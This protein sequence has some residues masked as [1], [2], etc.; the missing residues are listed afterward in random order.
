MYLRNTVSLALLVLLATACGTDLPG[1]ASTPEPASEHS[2]TEP[3][4]S[5]PDSERPGGERPPSEPIDGGDGGDRPPSDGPV[6]GQPDE[7]PCHSWTSPPTRK[8]RCRV[9]SL[10]ET[11]CPSGLVYNEAQ[12]RCE[13]L[14]PSEVYRVDI[15][16]RSTPPVPAEPPVDV[17]FV[18]RSSGE[19]WPR[20]SLGALEGR[21]AI[22]GSER[23]AVPL[24]TDSDRLRL[25]LEPGRYEVLFSYRGSESASPQLA[26][27]TKRRNLEI[28]T[29]GEFTVDLPVS[30]L[31][32]TITYNGGAY[33]DTLRLGE[34]NLR[35]ERFV[36]GPDGSDTGRIWLNPGAYELYVGTEYGRWPG[37]RI[38]TSV[39]EVVSIR[40]DVRTVAVSGIT[41]VDGEPLRQ[42]FATLEFKSEPLQTTR[43]VPVFPGGTFEVQLLDGE[44][45]VWLTSFGPGNDDSLPF[46]RV[47][48]KKGYRPTETRL[49][50][51]ASVLEV[52]GRVTLNGSEVG[53]DPER[54]MVEF[55]GP[56]AYART[57]LHRPGPGE[58]KTLI[59]DATYDVAL[60]GSAPFP[61]RDV[62]ATDWVATTASQEWN[63]ESIVWTPAFTFNGRSPPG[64]GGVYLALVRGN[65][66]ERGI[67]VDQPTP[68]R[69]GPGTYTVAYRNQLI[70][71]LPTGWDPRYP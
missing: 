38:E 25:C 26:S 23:P 50:L 67:R 16:L 37:G 21:M 63:V 30:A 48:V 54:A 35:G 55:S 69:L 20:S 40:E 56:G 3:A 44:Y 57:S 24:P 5:A 41:F 39:G 64:D 31:D 8:E 11:C 46:G 71:D 29:N 43:R 1:P 59:Y 61:A 34:L 19:L 36:R 42:S 49:E 58:F 62:L 9:P 27:M 15:N 22:L 18:L 68:L 10:N 60:S 65:G 14:T 45:D 47:L 12:S 13:P 7:P 32:Y 28:T 6:D 17:T 2:P 52:Q 51:R 53:D 4:P 66:V 33:P 70:E